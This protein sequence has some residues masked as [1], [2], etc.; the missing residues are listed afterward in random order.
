MSK[1]P[2]FICTVLL[3]CFGHHAF[4]QYSA[5]AC[6]AVPNSKTCVDKTPCKDVGG[7]V[8]CL[9]GAALPGG[10]ISIPQTCW[11]YSYDFACSSDLVN[12]CTQFEN[13]KACEIVS[14]KCTSTIPENGQCSS[15]TNVYSC[16][17]KAA[18][19]E[20]KLSCS[21]GV[22]DSASMPDP[23][24]V[25][26]TFSK[27]ALAQEILRESATYGKAGTAIFAG[28]SET[29]RKGYFGIK[30]CCKSAPGATPNSVMMNVA[31]SGAFSAVKYAGQVAVDAASPYV[32]DAMYTGGE[33]MS[34][35][36]SSFSSNAA[37]SVADFS[38]SVPT[39]T[40]FA[41][42][43]PSLS[44]YG[45]TYQSGLAAQGSGFMG[46][47][48]TIATF[49][50][51]S[52]MTSVTFNPYVFGALVAIQVIQS[53]RSCSQGEQMLSLHMGANL[54]TFVKEE[55]TNKIPIIGTCIE[56]T[57]TYCS[58]NSVLARLINM[59]GKPQLGLNTSNCQGLTVDQIS[60]IDFTKIDFREFTGQMTQ[61]A[62]KNMPSN[63]SGNYTPIMQ[64]Q[65]SGSKQSGSANL[66][67]YK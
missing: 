26:N 2:T 52:S 47:N 16:L 39:S 17:T 35:M 21:S 41:A 33:Y 59:Q 46:A 3:F 15:Y 7:K 6:H 43:G 65:T 32:F 5:G 62:T 1:L 40:N 45:F 24:N 13:N 64:Q 44:A 10:A 54:S 57:S 12:T 53:L 27:A 55:C 48:T 20:Q 28:V 42:G 19:T 56:W 66:P 49:G 63:V 9:T 25:N 37:S 30:N 50:E 4:A 61:Q 34:G 51:G 36:L 60:K 38:S 58:F 8:A 14:S 29:C 18:Q 31:L 67:S 11:Q 22:F 23:T